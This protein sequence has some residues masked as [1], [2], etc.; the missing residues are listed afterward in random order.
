MKIDLRCGRIVEC[1]RVPD[2][3]SLYLLKAGGTPA[4]FRDCSKVSSMFLT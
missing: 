4:M 2:A 3:D 1:S